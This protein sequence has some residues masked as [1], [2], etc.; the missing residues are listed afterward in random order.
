MNTATRP[1]VPGIGGGGTTVTK[2][3][4][5][6]TWPGAF[7]STTGGGTTWTWTA[8]DGSD[9]SASLTDGDGD[10]GDYPMA[11]DHRIEE[12]D[13]SGYVTAVHVI[14]VAGPAGWFRASLAGG[15]TINATKFGVGTDFSGY[16]FD[17]EI[18]LL[19]GRMSS[20]SCGARVIDIGAPAGT[21][22]TVML[23]VGTF[24]GNNPSPSSANIG[25]CCLDAASL[26]AN[27]GFHT[28]MSKNTSG[29]DLCGNAARVGTNITAVGGCGAN[30]EIRL[31]TSF[32]GGGTTATGAIALISG[33]SGE[34]RTVQDTDAIGTFS[35]IRLGIYVEQQANPG[36]EPQT[37]S[38][39]ALWYRWE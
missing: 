10:T 20:L 22:L 34:R 15:T 38:G 25:V 8:P 13:G 36:T 27:H 30:P 29:N 2:Q 11:G 5:A 16:S 26:V 23:D 17:V 35:A 39:N 6:Q 4:T 19:N 1:Q 14:T 7:T 32:L 33:D 12:V 24:S 9:Q 28:A 21:L 3:T 37:Y 18:G 31:M